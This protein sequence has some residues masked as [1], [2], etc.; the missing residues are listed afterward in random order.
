MGIAN[1]IPSDPRDEEKMKA[2]LQQ[3]YTEQAWDIATPAEF[4]SLA[5]KVSG[6]DLDALFA[7][8]VYPV[9]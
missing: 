6:Q 7:E 4:Q 2:F 9:P 5:E 8:W 1:P 3:Y